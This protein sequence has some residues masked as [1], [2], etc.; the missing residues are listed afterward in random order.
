MPFGLNVH[1][2]YNDGVDFIMHLNIVPTNSYVAFT[3]TENIGL[4]H[5][6]KCEL[7]NELHI[8][9]SYLLHFAFSAPS[10]IETGHQNTL[11]SLSTDIYSYDNVYTVL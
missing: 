1:I 5:R 2:N 3:L 10:C 7:L 11:A 4:K 6:L 9:E 8:T